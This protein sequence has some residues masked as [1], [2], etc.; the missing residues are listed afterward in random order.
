MTRSLFDLAQ[1][2]DEIAFF[3]GGAFALQHVLAIAAEP[4]LHLRRVGE[5]L[6]VGRR[7]Q[8]FD[9]LADPGLPHLLRVG[10]MAAG[11]AL[12]GA[13]T[14]RMLGAVERFAARG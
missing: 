14:S 12:L 5:A 6:R 8:R 10:G 7:S 9:G 3:L 2:G 1:P 13:V 11:A 4:F